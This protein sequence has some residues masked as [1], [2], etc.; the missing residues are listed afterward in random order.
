M[1]TFSSYL[2]VT[3]KDGVYFFRRIPWPVLFTHDVKS[4]HGHYDEE[5]I[6]FT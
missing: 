3:P 1:T 6:K 5:I 4:Y 2:E